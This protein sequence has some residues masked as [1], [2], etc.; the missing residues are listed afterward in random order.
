MPAPPQAMHFPELTSRTGAALVTADA[1]AVRQRLAPVSLTVRG[2]GRLLIT[3]PNGAGKSTLLAT[4]A[5][6]LQPDQGSVH[7]SNHGRCAFLKQESALPLDQRASR[8]YANHVDR[9]IAAGALTGQQAVGMASLGLL[10]SA[11]MNKRVGELSVGQQLRLDLAL[12]LAARPNLLLLD[13]PTNHLSIT[14]VDELTEAFDA[15]GA[16]GVLS[17][18]DRQQLRDLAHWPQLELRPVLAQETHF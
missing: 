4:L 18:H 9:L 14:L 8:V 12:T 10:R 3:G 6:E 16:A 1:A 7:R 11:E 15:T 5:G 17:S 2:R 13:E